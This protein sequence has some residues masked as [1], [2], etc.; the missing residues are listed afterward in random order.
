LPTEQEWEKAARGTDGRE[1]PW[2]EWAE[3]RCN[4]AEACIGDTT[5]VG[6]YSPQG[7]SP[8]G[9]QDCAGNVWEWTA[10][11]YEPGSGIRVLRGGALSDGARFVLC[12]DRIGSSPEAVGRGRDVVGSR[13]SPDLWLMFVRSQG[14]RVVAAPAPPVLPYVD[15]PHGDGRE[16]IKRPRHEE[17]TVP[18][19]FWRVSRL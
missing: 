12:T 10:S 13:G 7:D 15:S 8:Y 9:C 2:G 11:E 6:Q 17:G 16:Q 14:F 19:T 1:Y 5:P 3:G 18:V 4:S